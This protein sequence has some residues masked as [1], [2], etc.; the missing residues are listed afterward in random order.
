MSGQ[1]NLLTVDL[2][3]WYVVEILQGRYSF[4]DWPQL[5]STLSRNV[6]RLLNLF[7]RRQVRATW[8]VLGWCAERFPS[9]ISEIADQGHEIA[10]HS[11]RH[12][13]VDKL[14][15]EGFRADT[16]R[17]ID[18]I[19]S[20]TGFRPRGY[21][22]P[23][24]SINERVSWAFQV[25]SDLGFEYDSSIFP[26]KHDIYGMPTAPR[27]LFKMSFKNGRQLWEVPSSTLR[28]FGYNLPMAGGG[29][30]RHSPYWY[31]RMMIKQLNRRK[32][33]AMVYL[34]P[35]ELDPEP[36]RLDGL[37]PVQRFRTYGST[38]L[39]GSKLDKLLQDF[40]F[41]TVTDYVNAA[42]KRRIGFEN[43]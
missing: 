29:Y 36:P 32:L 26:I 10:C 18:A 5:P 43:A 7:E 12:L 8:F 15:E 19:K 21:R 9:L 11:Y 17:A 42:G 20:A 31:S 25:L 37:T 16:Q 40:E 39:F 38:A 28:I 2:E 30:L 4:E 22:A 34:H 1:L 6:Y 27:Q 35:W 13:R 14:D 23:S 41:T 3:E 24:W 33:P